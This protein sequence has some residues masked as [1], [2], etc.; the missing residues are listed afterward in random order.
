GNHG[1]TTTDGL[2]ITY[3]PY[4]DFNGT[5]SFMYTITDGHGGYD[6]AT[7]TITV[8]P[9]NDA[10]SFTIGPGG[11]V[12]VNARPQTVPAWATHI[13]AGPSDE[14]GQTLTF[15][16]VDLD[17]PSIFTSGAPAIDPITGNLTFE[18]QSG[19][20]STATIRVQLQDNGGTANGGQ[21]ASAA[22]YFT[23]TVKPPN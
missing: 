12:Q 11:Q 16:V 19:V 20:V 8:N 2:T 22:Q 9:V 18:V 1:I 15:V 23:I 17:S 13:G 7:I 10:P 21:D 3:T 14:A 6:S 5:D 4:P